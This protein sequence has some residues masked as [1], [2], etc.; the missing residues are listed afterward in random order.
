MEYSVPIKCDTKKT[1]FCMY[2]LKKL[3]V[4]QDNHWVGT[5]VMKQVEYVAFHKIKINDIRQY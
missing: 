1:P 5:S 4:L 3:D 2:F